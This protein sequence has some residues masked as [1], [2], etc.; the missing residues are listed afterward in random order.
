[1]TLINKRIVTYAWPQFEIALTHQISLVVLILFY[2]IQANVTVSV[3][4]NLNRASW[5]KSRR[6][7]QGV[8]LQVTLIITHIVAMA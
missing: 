3:S 5:P 4:Y 6:T 1:M 7:F 8:R 2:H